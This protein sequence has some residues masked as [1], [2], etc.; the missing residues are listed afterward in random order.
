MLLELCYFLQ[1]DENVLFSDTMVKTSW[2]TCVVL[3]V[4]LI[5]CWFTLRELYTDAE[6]GCAYHHAL[7]VRSYHVSISARRI[8][9]LQHVVDICHSCTRQ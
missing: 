6:D 1:N 8:N 2:L 9:N 5:H 3:D 4:A 7:T